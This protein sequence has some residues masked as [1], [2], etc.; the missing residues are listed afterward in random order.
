MA[1][2]EQHA[3]HLAPQV[4]RFEGLKQLDFAFARHLL[5]LAVA[6]LEGFAVKIVQVRRIIG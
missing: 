6:L 5:I 2:L 4:F 1:S 3:Q